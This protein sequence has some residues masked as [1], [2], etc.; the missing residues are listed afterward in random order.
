MVRDDV[1]A[2]LEQRRGEVISGGALA[3]QLGVSRTAVWKAITSLKADG[4]V[5]ESVPGEGY[6]LSPQNDVLSAAGIRVRLHTSEIASSLEVVEQIESTNTVLKRRAAELPSGYALVADSQ[7]GGRGRRGRSFLSPSGTGVYLSI[8]LRPELPLAQVNTLTIGAA[9][10]ACR[11]FEEAAGFRP[12][13]KW[14][15]DVLKDGKKLCGIL[16]E[17]SIEA[18]T[19]ALS[20]VVVGIGMNVRTPESG[21][22]EELRAIA[23]SLEDFSAHPVDRNHLTAAFLNHMEECY[24]LICANDLSAL[25]AQY[26]SYID[27]LRQPIRILE[28]GSAREATALEIDDC[29]HLIVESNGTRET[30]FAGEI[31]I[32]LPEQTI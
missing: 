24:R 19:G 32:R 14:V 22:P 8:L 9:V 20:Y 7:T 25:L 2:A 17:A 15:N 12:S 26:R 28:N 5:I 27:F 6:R 3:K 11:A 1:L 13:I 18:E 21:F 31:S 29:G 30:L 23:G 4:H 10:A 16:T